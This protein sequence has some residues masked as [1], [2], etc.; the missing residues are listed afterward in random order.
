MPRSISNRAS[1]RC[2]ASSAIGEITGGVRPRALRRAAASIS[3]SSKNLRRAWA[4]QA[5]SRIGAPR[6]LGVVQLAVAAIGVGLQDAA[7]ARQMLLGM[8]ARAVARVEEHRRRWCP[9]AERPVVAY[10][11]PTSAGDGLALGQHRHRRV[12]AVQTLGGQH[13]GQKPLMQRPQHRA[14]G[15]HLSASVD[16]LKRHAFAGVALGL[17]VERLMLAVLLEQDHRQQAG[18]GP[19]SGDRHGTAPAP[20]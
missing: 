2:T 1:I 5:A 4:Q 10:I 17:A 6:S 14:A 9:A 20:G 7:P 15:A 11:G 12:V 3:A 18:A 19:A 16:R 8:L 13:M